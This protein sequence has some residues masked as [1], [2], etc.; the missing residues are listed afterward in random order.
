MP[1]IS[2]ANRPSIM[3]MVARVCA[4]VMPGLHAFAPAFGATDPLPGSP[5]SVTTL[6]TDVSGAG[7]LAASINGQTVYC[8]DEAR[9]AVVALDPFGAGRHRDVV[10]PA[11]DDLPT[12]VAVGCLPGDLL[13]LVCRRGDEWTVRTHRIRPGVAADPAEPVQTL[14]VGRA[15]GEIASVDLAV[16]RSRDWL[17]VVGIPLPVAPVLRAMFAG[18]SMRPLSDEGW[19]A[20]TT[21]SRPLAIA[22][23]PA[24]EIVLLEATDAAGS[25][26]VSFHGPAGRELLRLDTGLQH[27]RGVA[28]A[29]DGSALWVITGPSEAA[30][31]PGGLWRLDAV[32]RDGRQAVRPVCLAMLEEPRAIAAVSDRSV[33]VVHG[34]A[35][36]T[37]VRI[38]SSDGTTTRQET[39]TP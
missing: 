3:L 1:P 38:D 22:V 27:V 25:A 24:E 17:A 4:A 7:D 15:G 20:V 8:I 18:A 36:R 2:T 28:C 16:G 39:I 13:A 23:T 31:R 21:G 6:S 19:P 35:R 10:A 26:A 37:I 11:A 14:A 12:P 5:A 9:R 32:L 29:R 30:N 34:T 33:V